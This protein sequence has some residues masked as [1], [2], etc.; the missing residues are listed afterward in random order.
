MVASQILALLVEVRVLTG[1]PT[2]DRGVIDLRVSILQA[3]PN[4]VSMI[5]VIAG[6]C[7][8]KSDPSHKRVERCVANGHTS[9]LEHAIVTFDID[10]ISRICSHQ[11]VRHR[12]AS[13]TQA[14]QRYIKEDSVNIVIPDKIYDGKDAEVIFMDAKIKS[15]EAYHKLLSI[16]VPA[17][18][19]RFILPQASSTSIVVTMNARSLFNFFSLRQDSHAQ[20]EIRKLAFEMERVL[21]D[22]SDE[23][24]ELLSMRNC[25]QT[26]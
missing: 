5:G 1:K 25:E 2:N 21:S 17:E 15:E 3:T 26:D 12:M 18:D 24:C 22:Y 20:W 14:S 19:A 4:P 13:Y 11:L 9:I 6:K 10:G 8:G 23:W 16:G 7:Y